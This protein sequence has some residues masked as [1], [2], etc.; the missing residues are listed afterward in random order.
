MMWNKAEVTDDTGGKG[1]D[2]LIISNKNM[3]LSPFSQEYKA[4]IQ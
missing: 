3:E 4:R 1:R 2:F